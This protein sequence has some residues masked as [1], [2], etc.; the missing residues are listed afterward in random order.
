MSRRSCLNF[1]KRSLVSLVLP[2]LLLTLWEWSI[3][4]HRIP[5]TIL[6]SP[7]Q[8]AKDFVLFLRNG[9]L[10]VHCLASLRRLLLGYLIG[11]IL[12]LVLGATVGVSKFTQRLVSPTIQ[13]LVP[14]PPES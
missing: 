7:S 12:G 10:F 13:F 5:N 4:T 11:T 6:A 1:N 3:D 9:T 14:I 8:V 2:I